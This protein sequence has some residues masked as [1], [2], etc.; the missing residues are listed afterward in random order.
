MKNLI[1]IVLSISFA[2]SELDLRLATG[3]SKWYD[4]N[5]E[6][7]S[8]S[9]TNY[10]TFPIVQAKTVI[11]HPINNI[12]DI[13]GDLSSYPKVFKRIKEAKELDD[14]IVHI[15]IDMPFPFDGRDYVVKFNI[16]KSKNKW[17]LIYSSVV[18]PNAAPDRYTRLPNAAG[19]WELKKLGS[20][21]TEVTYIWN[22]ELLGNFPDIGLNKA[23]SI[24]GKE[25]FNWLNE[26]L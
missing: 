8:I 3:I 1:F 26:A 25:I 10:K 16:K 14:N 2:F 13:I 22:G 20:N 5:S 12:A 7:V 24:W 15:I 19:V 18:H 9:W 4:L 6:E 17:M 11:D 21:K 23:W